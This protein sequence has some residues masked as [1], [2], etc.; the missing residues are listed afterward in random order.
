MIPRCLLLA[1]T[2]FVFLSS[3]W[4]QHN[5]PLLEYKYGQITLKSG[6]G[7][8]FYLGSGSDANKQGYSKV[9]YLFTD[10]TKVYISSD[11]YGKKGYKLAIKNTNP[12]SRW[13]IGDKWLNR[14]FI[15]QKEVRS[16]SC[17]WL[18]WEKRARIL[19]DT[20]DEQTT[21]VNYTVAL[22]VLPTPPRDTF[23]TTHILIN[24][25]IKKGKLTANLQIG[26]TGR[27]VF[28]SVWIDSIP[29]QNIIY[30]G[31]YKRDTPYYRQDPHANI[32]I[33][34]PISWLQK[35]ISVIVFYRLLSPDGYIIPKSEVLMIPIR[36]NFLFLYLSIALALIVILLL[37]L[38]W[39]Y[40]KNKR[41]KQT[42]NVLELN[43]TCICDHTE[44]IETDIE[45]QL[46]KTRNELE[47][48]EQ[49]VHELRNQLE[50]AKNKKYTP[51]DSIEFRRRCDD[52]ICGIDEIYND[53]IQ[54]GNSMTPNE[55]AEKI[56]QLEKKI[57]II[58]QK[59]KK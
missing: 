38:L 54:N 8:L 52:V 48:K 18:S 56:R 2:V 30:N 23:I 20:K 4:G 35:K 7:E 57:N 10:S 44:D 1:A 28:D 31:S 46:I 37:L 13:F 39:I 51:E 25:K 32:E 47:R 40:K 34:M 27:I 11:Y 24:K 21:D 36:N 22:I 12:I 45:N 19:F 59:T 33:N 17:L 9:Y 6:D 50:K 49:Q 5:C 26:R 3:I 53:L 29:Q 55:V 43:N 16:S 58:Q 41:N 14:S 42:S 15:T